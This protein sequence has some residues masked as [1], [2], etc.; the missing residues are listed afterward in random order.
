MRTVKKYIPSEIESKWQTKWS[1]SGTYKFKFDPKK[2]KYYTLVELPYPSGDLHIGHWFTF[3]TPDVL[4]RF[5]RMKGFNVFFPHGYDAFGLPAENA[6]IKRKIHP[7]DWTM[8]N[9]ETMT[10]Q[11]RTMGSIIDLDGATITCLPE[12][13]KWNQWIFQKMYEKGLAYRG[14]VLSNWCEFDKTVLANEHVENGKCWRCGNPVVQKEVEQWFLK[15]TEY[16]DRLIWPE[17]PSVDWPM[18]V[19]VGQN[20]WIG[21]STGVELTYN[22]ENSKESVTVFTTALDTVYGVTFLVLSPEHPLVAK[23]TSKEQKEAV[24]AYVEKASRKTELERLQDDKNKT[25]VF[26]GSYVINPF[27]GKKVPVWV[28]D[29][30][31]LNYG[32]GAVMGVPGHDS[33]DHAFA[34]KFDLPIKIVVRPMANAKNAAVA[35]DGFWDY[36]DIKRHGQDSEV[37]DSGE[38]SGFSYAEAKAKMEDFIELKQFGKRKVQYHIRDWS[39]SRQ[40]YWGTPVPMIHCDKCGIVPVPENELPIELPYE[41]DYMPKGK[42][43]LASNEEWLNVKCPK[44]GGEAK[45]DAETLDTFFD[46]SWYFFR[47]TDNKFDKGP[48]DQKKVNEVMPLDIYF[49]GAE[50][51]LGHTLYA[52]FFTKFFKDIGLIDFDE[53]ALKRIQHGIVLGPDGSKMSKSIGNVIN[54][55]DVVKEYGADAVRLYLNFMMPYEATA[56]WSTQAI[57]GIF[58]FLQRVWSLKEKVSDQKVMTAD[59]TFQLND[60]VKKVERDLEQIKNNTA[61]AFIMT[62]LNYLS[63]Q[64]KIAKEEYKTLLLVLAPFAPHITEELWAQ[65]GE[66]FSIHNE[67]WPIA[68]EGAQSATTVKIPVQINGKVRAVLQV[69]SSKLDEKSVEEMALKEETVQKHLEGKTHKTIYVPGKILNLVAP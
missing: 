17:K 8:S 32:T 14:K 55:D 44:C 52:R 51:T 26:T 9:I 13:Y 21:R 31:L 25:G 59:D 43:P 40:R 47:Y 53:F 7:K 16:A 29:Y 6:A 38:F 49:G 58:R 45:R 56:P 68:K 1:E 23:V 69:P 37:F 62:W 5:K 18:S 33:R 3:V 65:I 28:A 50:H 61:I 46:S 20:A 60:T 11:F 4:S 54:P 2:K 42:P 35:K 12:Y 64:E 15:I 67:A 57:A 30:V 19:R 48:F 36:Q 27:N 39:V 10:A 41:V 34:R 66:K 22:F 24:N 63:K